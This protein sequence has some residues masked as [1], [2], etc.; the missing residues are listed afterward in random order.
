MPLCMNPL[1]VWSVTIARCQSLTVQR[2]HVAP[3]KKL[4]ARAHTIGHAH[5]ATRQTP[6]LVCAF[7]P[8]M[9][10]LLLVGSRSLRLNR[11]ESLASALVP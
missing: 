5:S 2:D 10:T 3:G 6:P 7:F 4:F 8:A 1:L 11:R 9:R